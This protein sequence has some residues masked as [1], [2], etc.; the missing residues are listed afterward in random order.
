M[1]WFYYYFQK[2]RLAVIS[3][4]TGPCRTWDSVFAVWSSCSLVIHA[5]VTE[6]SEARAE[7]GFWHEL[8]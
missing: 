5:V 6:K 7:V 3:D 8:V 1:L 2:M 4:V